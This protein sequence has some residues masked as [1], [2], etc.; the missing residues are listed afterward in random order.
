MTF[1][2][3]RTRAAV[4]AT[5]TV[6]PTHEAQQ[7]PPVPPSPGPGATPVPTVRTKPASAPARSRLSARGPCAS[8][9]RPSVPPR[10]TRG[11]A[12]T[13]ASSTRRLPTCTCSPTC[14]SG[15]GSTCRRAATQLVPA[16]PPPPPTTGRARAS[17]RSRRAA[18]QRHPTQRRSRAAPASGTSRNQQSFRSC[19]ARYAGRSPSATMPPVVSIQT[20]PQSARGPGLRRRAGDDS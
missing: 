16:S 11:P 19:A 1:T 12:P 14:W 9:R 18:R 15:F 13:S 6:P 3:P 20:R 17:R 8:G 10:A 7:R 2:T 4:L 5:A